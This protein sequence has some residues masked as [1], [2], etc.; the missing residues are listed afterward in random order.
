MLTYSLKALQVGTHAAHHMTAN[1]RLISCSKLRVDAHVLLDIG[2][3]YLRRDR[4]NLSVATHMDSEAP[5]QDRSR[6][7]R[8]F[9]VRPHE[10]ITLGHVT[11]AS[12]KV[13]PG[14]G[15]SRKWFVL[16]RS[17]FFSICSA[18]RLPRPTN[19]TSK[20]KLFSKLT[21]CWTTCSVMFV[22][23]SLQPLCRPTSDLL[24]LPSDV[25]IRL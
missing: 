13:E 12:G 4:Y 20:D 25:D 9:T 17:E 16:R 2:Y 19:C 14:L 7:S 18:T 5:D 11:I 8:W 6:R 1:I 15:L 22:V 21:C 10:F 24:W 3:F 23:L